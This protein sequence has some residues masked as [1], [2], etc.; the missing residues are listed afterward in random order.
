[1]TLSFEERADALIA[2]SI[3]F[4]RRSSQHDDTREKRSVTEVVNE[5]LRSLNSPR[6]G[7]LNERV[8][9]IESL[10]DMQRQRWLGQ[11]VDNLRRRGRSTKLDQHISA[12]HIARALEKEPSPIRRTIL[13]YLP[14]DL[15]SDVDRLI[16]PE[17]R[18]DSSDHEFSTDPAAEIIEVVKRAF[19]ANFVQIESVQDRNALDELSIDELRNFMPRPRAPRDRRRLSRY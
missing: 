4:D 8:A 16:D 5:S 6:R 7:K 13:N 1:M 15:S 3:V 10:S 18:T 19:L 2:L 14:P 12:E 17:T 11:W 9:E